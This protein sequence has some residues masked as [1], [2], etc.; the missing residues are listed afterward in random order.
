M[1]VQDNGRGFDSQEPGSGKEFG[2]ASIRERVERIG[3]QIHVSDEP[4]QGIRIIVS[5]RLP[6]PE[7]QRRAA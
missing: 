4:G 7:A 5:A 6:V 3:A 1:S 2:L